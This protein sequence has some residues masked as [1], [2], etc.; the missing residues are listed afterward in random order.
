MHNKAQ[1]EY[2]FINSNITGGADEIQLRRAI[3]SQ[4]ARGPSIAGQGVQSATKIRRRRRKNRVKSWPVNVTQL[5]KENDLSVSPGCPHS[6]S[7][8]SSFTPISLSSSG[9]GPLFSRSAVLELPFLPTILDNCKSCHLLSTRATQ[10]SGQ[11]RI[12]LSKD[13]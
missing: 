3:R 12:F 11:R 9:W 8:R 1:L 13:F 6:A 5:G 7:T 10:F 2:E 4:A